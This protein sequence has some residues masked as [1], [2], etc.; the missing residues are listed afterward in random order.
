MGN[1]PVQLVDATSL[2]TVRESLDLLETD[3][4]KLI[5]RVGDAAQRVH[6]GIGLSSHSLNAI[7]GQTEDLSTLAQAANEDAQQLAAATQ[8]FAAS[9]NEIGRNVQAAGSL[10]S[11]ATQVAADA[12]ESIES[13]NASSSAI[14]T[15]IGLIAKIAKQ[16]QLL[17][18]NATIEAARAGD[19]GRGF[20]VV[21]HEIKTLSIETQKATDEIRRRVAQL[22]SDTQA[23]NRALTRI[24]S[25]IGEVQ[26]VY[27]A[28]A[29]AV[30][31]Q[32]TTAHGISDNAL[33]TSSFIARVSNSAGEIKRAAD[34]AAGESVEV[35]RSGRTAAE[36][37]AKLRRNLSIFLR[38]TEIGDRRRSDRLP[39]E[40]VATLQGS[41]A[42]KTVDISTGGALVQ[43]AADRGPA[44]IG[45]R[46]SL[47]IAEIGRLS[48]EVVNRSELGLHLK[49]IDGSTKTRAAL[50]QKV[51]AIQVENREFIDLAKKA[52][53]E[54]SKCLEQLIVSQ[55]LT[56]ASL[57]DNDYAPIPGSNPQQY[58]TRYLDVLDEVLPPIQERM[59][60]SDERMVFS[61][62]IDRNGY[63]PVH[64]LKYSQPQ[65][66]GDLAWNTPNCRNRRI[67]D[68][69]AGLCAA[70]SARPYLIQ[71]YPRD[72][73]N[74]VMVLMKEIDVPV[75][76]LGKH[77]GGFRM[78]YKI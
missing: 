71:S 40:L 68:D 28:I 73:G 11:K 14:G 16:T 64:N 57:F 44:E 45:H 48:A 18:L 41:V 3:L 51:F 13:L 30:E 70:R 27:S 29:S 36:L 78:A 2:S 35:D 33:T 53:A 24:A 21:A 5:A 4:A 67:F 26:P 55:R 69:R 39:C 50:E 17:A 10:T 25:V 75:R 6:V 56:A 20:A 59:L 63:I 52:G 34:T 46:V 54:I 32:I 62:A 7:R 22:Q 58:R 31:E 23:S 60:A 38:Q 42:S 61:I 66:P 9:S 49:F 74:G 37:A 43:A 19:A 8:E 76:V 15:I 47:E 77:W 12:G 65:R 72:M 1:E